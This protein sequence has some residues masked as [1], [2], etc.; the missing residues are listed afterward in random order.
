MNGIRLPAFLKHRPEARAFS[1]N[2]AWL[3]GDKLTRFL[4]A[5]FVSAWVARYLGPERYGVLAYAIA[6]IS[7]FQAVSLLG[8]DNLIV[9]DIAASP[10][11]AG[12]VLGTALRLRLIAAGISYLA[13]GAWIVLFQREDMTVSVVVLLAGL[14]ILFQV[15]DVI[16]LWFQ[17]R[18]QSRR[19][20]VA[21]ISPAWAT[22][23]FKVL[24]IQLGASLPAFAA[25]NALETG[26]AAIAL[27]IAYAG[28][29]TERR[30]EW[31]G[32]LARALLAQSWPLLLSGLSIL[33]YMRVSI[34]FL[35][36]SA[37]TAEVGFYG[38]AATLSE[39]W[40]FIPMALGSSIAPIVSRQR[41]AGSDAHRRTLL[42]AFAGMWALSLSVVVVNILGAR[43]FV[44]LLYG[45]QYAASAPLLALHAL[46]FIPV[47]LGVMQSVWLI[48]E[49]RSRLALHQALSG[50]LTALVL[51]LILTP[52]YGAYGAAIATVGAQFVQAFLVNA[53]LAPDLFRLQ[54]GSLRILKTLRS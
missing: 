31:D 23:V 13:L 42:K 20:V 2:V 43:L 4:V 3:L 39:M 53:L 38:V 22:A 36:E 7:M 54:C 25:A 9:R 40:Y 35:R 47:C 29:R 11:Q 33:L 41:A 46:T 26:L 28:Y 12:R 45:P 8:L 27:V 50:A 30:W 17:S 10:A 52:R 14:A 15:S 19:T 18:I 37:G 49:G 24:L 44:G 5:I 32:A 1:S 6:F 48:N 21:K 34:V 16:D 51:N